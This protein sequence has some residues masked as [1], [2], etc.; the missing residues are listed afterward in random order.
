MLDVVDISDATCIETLIHSVVKLV[1]TNIIFLIL[2]Y[3]NV[4]KTTLLEAKMTSE[5]YVKAGRLLNFLPKCG[6]IYINI[7]AKK[8]AFFTFG[9]AEKWGK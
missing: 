2:W 6:I 8:V 5:R 4:N 7:Y 9:G 1:K 3:K